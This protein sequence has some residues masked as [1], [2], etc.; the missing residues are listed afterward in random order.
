MKHLQPLCYTAMSATTARTPCHRSGT[1]RPA[2]TPPTCLA[3][4]PSPLSQSSRVSSNHD[5]LLKVC[6]MQ[7]EKSPCAE[8]LSAKK[9]FRSESDAFLHLLIKHNF[10][11]KALPCFVLNKDIKSVDCQPHQ[12]AFL[13]PPY[14]HSIIFLQPKL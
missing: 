2:R 12:L 10:V 8:Q 6:T 5:K 3:S 9:A 11:L 14:L 7:P 13:H 1:W 4:P